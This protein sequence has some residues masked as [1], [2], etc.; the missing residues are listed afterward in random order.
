LTVHTPLQVEILKMLAEAGEENLATIFNTVLVSTADGAPA[1]IAADVDG[2]LDDLLDHGLIE[3]AQ[4]DGEW[5]SL[6]DNDSRALRPF[7][8]SL[9]WVP[10][11]GSWAW[12]EARFGR[13]RVA[14]VLS[15]AGRQRAMKLSR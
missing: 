2:A 12:D 15:P 10:D 14:A 7:H 6:P 8:R 1:M 11:S 4:W 3:L 5:I 9:I 13:R